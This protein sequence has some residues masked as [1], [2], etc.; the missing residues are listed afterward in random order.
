[1]SSKTT[2]KEGITVLILPGWR[3]KST[4]YSQLQQL[5]EDHG[6]TVHTLDF[7]GFDGKKIPEKGYTLTDYAQFLELYIEK[8]KLTNVVFICHS[9]GGR[10]A[11]KYFSL[12]KNK[13]TIKGMILTGTPLVKEKFSTRKLAT[14][15]V[16]TYMRLFGNLIPLKTR[17]F[18]Q[19]NLRFLLY[20]IIG[21]YD[22]YKAG[23]LRKTLTNILED[24]PQKY[25]AG[26]TL[27][28]LIIWGEN[29]TITPLQTGVAIQQSIKDSKLIT[30]PNA[31]HK[32]PY[33]N[34][35]EF[36][37]YVDSFSKNLS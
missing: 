2:K 32:L 11:V 24:D 17:V 3:V 35:Q 26:V 6:Y 34:P 8:N 33:D 23:D 15:Q 14:L 36:A 7:P 9:F 18:L 37:H 28:T 25:L 22:Y 5:L 19:D 21:E 1:M 10:A 29:D 30:V 20:R 4:R 13:H 16:L 27:P 31:T 12:Y